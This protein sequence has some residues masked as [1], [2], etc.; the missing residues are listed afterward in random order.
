MKKLITLLAALALAVAAFA[1][2]PE[3]II[4]RM[5]EATTRFEAD[6][7][8]ADMD[9][10]VFL[11]T[12]KSK[13]F[14]RGD[15]ARIETEIMGEKLIVWTDGKTEWT[16][17]STNQTVTIKDEETSGDKDA[18]G[19]DLLKDIT[20]GYDVSLRKQTATQWSIRCKKSR[21][22]TDPDV[23]K[24]MDLVIDKNTCLPVSLTATMKEGT[25]VLHDFQF[26]QVSEAQVTFR[27]EDYPG[28]TTIDERK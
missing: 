24:T 18:D 4:Q 1:Q 28:V 8:S 25:L 12:I 19:A 10:K 22:N 7:F 27:P 5:D 17:D 14:T 23:P 9:L 13:M 20:S 15:K 3:E 2:T 16:Y 6:G 11:F 21:S 26:G